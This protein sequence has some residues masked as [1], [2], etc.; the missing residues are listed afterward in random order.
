[1]ARMAASSALFRSRRI[2]VIPYCLD[3]QVFCPTECAVARR[4]LSLPQD[5]HVVL[6][7][8]LTGDGDK[9]KGLHLLKSAF[10]SL[11]RNGTAGPIC[12]AVAGMNGDKRDSSFSFDVHYLGILKRETEMALAC[13]A[14]DVFVAPSMEDNLPNTVLEALSCGTP[15]V[16]FDIGGMGDMIDHRMNG[17]LAKPFDVDDL[18]MGIRWVL[19][20]ENRRRS[21]SD[22]ARKKAVEKYGFESIARRH[23]RLYEELTVTTK[24]PKGNSFC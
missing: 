17:Y 13:A 3:T 23:A 24:R 21:L 1:M 9:R 12:L 16:A 7:S 15:C 11:A 18:A 22:A 4:R 14:A 8:A 6:F 20:D 10:E 2:E 5:K 19:A